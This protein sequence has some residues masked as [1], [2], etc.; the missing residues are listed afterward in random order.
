MEISSRFVGTPLKEHSID[1]T[2]RDMMNYAAAIEDPNPLYFDDE[3][4]GGII[5]HPMFCVAVTWRTLERIW[6]LIE[7]HEF[8]V[9]LLATQVHYTEHLE[10]YRPIVPGDLLTLR[11]EIAAILP[12]RSGTI[13]IIRSDAFATDG[14]PAF[15]EHAG[16]LLRGVQCRN[17]G[18]GSEALPIV[19]HS[20]DQRSVIWESVIPIEPLRPFV[21]DGCTGISFPIHTSR[22]F[23]RQVGLPGIILQGTA[24]L[25]L[26]VRELVN[27]E[28]GGDPLSLRVLSAR[29]TGMV[30]PGTDIRLQ[31]VARRARQDGTGLHFGVL[32]ADGRRAISDGYAFLE[33]SSTG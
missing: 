16:T 30:L 26:A 24:T 21:Y 18:Q 11:G 31:L 6:D 7:D 13:V 9:H 3:Q 20:P 17:G 1:I 25:A 27:R 23:A 28:A 8:P 29:F 15:T 4:A 5:A 2:W 33:A 12:H 22:Q 10:F 14:S 32:N 19:P